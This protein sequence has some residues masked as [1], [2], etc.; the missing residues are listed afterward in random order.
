MNIPGDPPF[1]VQR[2]TPDDVPLLRALNAVF[3]EAFGEL[4]TYGG[5]PPTDAYLAGL[6]A[7]DHVVVLVAR[8]GGEVVGGLV[9]YDLEKFE[10]ARRE[11]YIYDLA[12]GEAHRRFG[13]AT[14]LIESLCQIAAE[15]GAWVVYV[16]ADY[17]DDDA[18]A[19]Y[20]KFGTS[21]S[22]LHFN[23]AVKKKS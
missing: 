5:D 18:I 13:I 12:V 20:R 16:Q 7:K 22:V 23:I 1:S 6:L 2:L 3:G 21:E 4:D 15:R 17:G 8:A 14:A 9:A 10:R 11:I 19:L